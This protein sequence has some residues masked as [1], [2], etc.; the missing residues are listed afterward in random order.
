MGYPTSFRALLLQKPE[1]P[2]NPPYNDVRIIEKP[3]PVLKRGQVLVR[4]NA[5]G[6]NHREVCSRSTARGNVCEFALALDSQRPVSWNCFWQHHGCRWRWS[7][8]SRFIA[9]VMPDH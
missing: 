5:A 1:E 4:I 6:F 9:T 3:I 7:V 8:I 2:R